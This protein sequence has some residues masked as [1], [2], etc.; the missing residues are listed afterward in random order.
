MKPRLLCVDDEPMVLEGLYPNLR[1][2]FDTDLCFTPQAA[3]DRLKTQPPYAVVMSDMRMPGMSGAQLLAAVKAGWPDTTRVL[4]T[5]QAE[6]ASAISAVNEGEIFRFLTK[7]CPAPALVQA[8]KAAAAQHGLV[9]A[10]HELLDRTLKGSILALAEVL[11]AVQPRAFG[12]AGRI[13]KISVA[14]AKHLGRTDTWALEM[15]GLLSVVGFAG[16]PAET[17]E[18]VFSGEVLKA[19]EQAMVDRVPKLTEQM[20]GHIPRLEPVR[21]LL[22]ALLDRKNAVTTLEAKVLRAVADWDALDARGVIGR[23]GIDRVAEAQKLPPELVAAMCAVE[24]T[25][26]GESTLVKLPLAELYPGLELADDVRTN[27]GVL[28]LSRG[29]TMTAAT[30]ERV[31]NV[32]RSAGVKEPILVRRPHLP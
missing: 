29:F 9:T 1:Q 6:M 8:L 31:R 18:R 14:V 19:D 30:L 17:V 7:P 16:L 2:H 25:M 4:L 27:A 21:T 24:A 3:L 32:A 22:Q 15:A 10:E 20:L 23:A 11:A 5:G 28:L 12:R 13:A 26:T